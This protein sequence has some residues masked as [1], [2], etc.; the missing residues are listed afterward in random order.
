MFRFMKFYETKCYGHYSTSDNFHTYF[1]VIL[2]HRLVNEKRLDV[3]YVCKYLARKG[4]LIDPASI[5]RLNRSISRPD[6]ANLR[7]KGRDQLPV[8]LRRRL[9][10]SV[11]W[12]SACIARWTRIGCGGKVTGRMDKERAMGGK[13]RE[14][15]S[16]VIKLR[17]G[18]NKRAKLT[19]QFLRLVAK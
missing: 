16:R 13:V 14:G 8:N 17:T 4:R 1:R 7:A 15:W 6:A 2:H 5:N 18:V 3:C 9:I 11:A 10:A 19:F 12:L